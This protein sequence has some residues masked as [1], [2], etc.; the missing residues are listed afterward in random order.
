MYRFSHVYGDLNDLSDSWL[1][2]KNKGDV[3]NYLTRIVDCEI[4]LLEYG[5]EW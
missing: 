5:M 3:D 1:F 4:L 2:A